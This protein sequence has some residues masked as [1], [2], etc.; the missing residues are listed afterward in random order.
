MLPA[1]EHPYAVQTLADPAIRLTSGA[2]WELPAGWVLLVNALHRDLAVLA[3]GY[4]VALIGQKAGGLRLIIAGERRL[5][6]A[7]RA[8]IDAAREASLEICDLCGAPADRPS[9]RTRLITRCPA[10]P[11]VGPGKIVGAAAAPPSN[12]EGAP[13]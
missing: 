9:W 10:H 13:S 12:P 7:M 2:E 11:A 1:A 6:P 5:D 8:R 4:A 3:G